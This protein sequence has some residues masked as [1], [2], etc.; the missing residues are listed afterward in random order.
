MSLTVWCVLTGSEI[1]IF[2]QMD[3]DSS[4]N[5]TTFFPSGEQKTDNLVWCDFRLE[6]YFPWFSCCHY[7]FGQAVRGT[8]RNLEMKT[9]RVIKFFNDSFLKLGV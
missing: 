2:H 8:V 4:L 6:D 1:D 9:V 7:L 3:Q 5:K